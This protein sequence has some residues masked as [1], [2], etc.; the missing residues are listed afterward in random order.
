MLTMDN[1][2][3]SSDGGET[4]TMTITPATSQYTQSTEKTQVPTLAP[5]L[6]LASLSQ[7]LEPSPPPASPPTRT[8]VNTCIIVLTVTSSMIINVRFFSKI[9]PKWLTGY[10]SFPDREHNVGVDCSSNNRKRDEPQTSTIAVDHVCVSSQ[11]SG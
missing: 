7:P 6:R 11:L 2:I 8:L 4:M 10:L 3:V 1:S 5:S 9:F